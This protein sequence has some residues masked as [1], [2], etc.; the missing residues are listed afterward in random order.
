MGSP[1]RMN[2]HFHPAMPNM[3]FICSSAPDNA[4][5]TTDEMGMA[6]MNHAIAR[7]RYCA[8]NQWPR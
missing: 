5:P 2:S 6:T 4:P 3:P 7:V 1:S 8:G